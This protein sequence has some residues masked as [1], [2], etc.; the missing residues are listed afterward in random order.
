MILTLLLIF[1]HVFMCVTFLISIVLGANLIV[2]N[3]ILASLNLMLTLYCFTMSFHQLIAINEPYNISF[4]HFACC[5][6]NGLGWPK[7]WP[8]PRKL[9]ILA[10]FGKPLGCIS[11]AC[12]CMVCKHCASL[13]YTQNLTHHMGSHNYT[14]IHTW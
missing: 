9:W 2:H 12:I 5:A 8:T 1:V 3:R 6:L 7:S 11:Y 13:F 10:M 14:I 4:S